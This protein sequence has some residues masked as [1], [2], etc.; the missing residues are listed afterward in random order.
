VNQQGMITWRQFDRDYKNRSS[1]KDILTA[2]E[3]L[4]QAD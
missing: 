2:L 4:K 1:V 3:E